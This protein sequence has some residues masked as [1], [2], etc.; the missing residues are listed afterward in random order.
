M[1]A[2]YLQLLINPF[3]VIKI[4]L[5][6]AMVVF[7]IFMLIIL[8][9]V[10]ALSRTINQPTTTIVS[11]VGIIFLLLAVSLFLTALVIL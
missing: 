5:F 3:F 10:R 7:A 6:I 1:Y 9:Q 2:N 8:N 4:I 11:A